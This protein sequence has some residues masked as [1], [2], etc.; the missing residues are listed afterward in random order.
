M[1]AA[2]INDFFNT[3]LEKVECRIITDDEKSISAPL[4]GYA[5]RTSY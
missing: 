4:S 5:L 2:L 1:Q 3:L